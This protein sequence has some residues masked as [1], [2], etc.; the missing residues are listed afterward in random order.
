MTHTTSMRLGK[1]LTRAHRVVSC[2]LTTCLVK[3]A[4]WCWGQVVTQLFFLSCSYL[5]FNIVIVKSL[6]IVDIGQRPIWFWSRFQS[7]WLLVL[8]ILVMYVTSPYNVLPVRSLVS[9]MNSSVQCGNSN[10][11]I[12]CSLTKLF[13]V[14]HR[15][16]QTNSV[17]RS[18][19]K[20]DKKYLSACRSRIARSWRRRSGTGF[21][22]WS[23]VGRTRFGWTMSF[24]DAGICSSLR[25]SSFVINIAINITI[26]I[27]SSTAN[28]I[29]NTM[30]PGTQKACVR[31]CQPSGDWQPQQDWGWSHHGG[32]W[33]FRRGFKISW[34]H[35]DC[36]IWMI[37]KQSVD[38]WY[39][40]GEIL[41]EK[42][43]NYIGRI[44]KVEVKNYIVIS[45]WII[46][47]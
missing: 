5:S 2:F 14:N 22:G 3:V 30:T 28:I 35:K 27:A 1:V 45:L 15:V 16:A 47:L 29:I 11:T 33:G 36:W 43:G 34:D 42:D 13:Q 46:T 41:E 20:T 6:R 9:L 8:N 44:Q 38:V 7:I 18:S 19:S 25:L 40:T 10:S 12:D 26:N 39:N 17:H 21:L 37:R 23:F 32:W 24:G 31:V 4:G